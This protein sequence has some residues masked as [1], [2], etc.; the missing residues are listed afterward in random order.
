MAVHWPLVCDAARAGA[1][2]HGFTFVA[3]SC[4]RLSWVRLWINYQAH[5][6]LEL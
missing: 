5:H 4:V 3:L 2:P 1:L 6:Y